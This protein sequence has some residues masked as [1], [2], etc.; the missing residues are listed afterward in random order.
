MECIAY[1]SGY[2]YQLKK[3]YVTTIDIKPDAPIDTG[4]MALTSEGTLTIR[5]GYAW[6]SPS[7]ATLDTLMGSGN[8][9]DRYTG[10]AFGEGL[11]DSFLGNYADTILNSLKQNKTEKT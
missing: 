5:N 11:E 8:I 9:L 6:D 10:G 2:K 3:D 7:D 1:K 4:Y